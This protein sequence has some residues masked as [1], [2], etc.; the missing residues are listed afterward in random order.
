[1][2]FLQNMLEMEV[3]T[4]QNKIPIIKEMENYR[5]RVC[6]ELGYAIQRDSARQRFPIESDYVKRQI[7]RYLTYI[8]KQ[9]S[10]TIKD[11]IHAIIVLV[12]L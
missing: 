5:C 2:H 10:Y 12:K 9:S 3:M 8:F 1:M 4:I 7:K 11:F 6:L